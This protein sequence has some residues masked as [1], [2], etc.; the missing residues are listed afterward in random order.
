MRR[1]LAARLAPLRPVILVALS[2]L[3]CESLLGAD[4]DDARARIPAPTEAGHA[5]GA[6]DGEPRSA[7]GHGGRSSEPLGGAS[8]GGRAEPSQAGAGGAGET[9]LGTAGEMP[10]GEGG[11]AGATTG[12]SADEGGAAGVVLG[13][14]GAAGDSGTSDACPSPV[15]PV[16][17]GLATVSPREIPAST[18]ARSVGVVRGGDGAPRCVAALVAASIILT[19]P[20][21]DLRA[22]DPVTFNA[23]R[24]SSGAEA[25]VTE[26]ATSGWQIRDSLFVLAGLAR[27]ANWNEFPQATM[28]ARLPLP[29]EQLRL[30]SHGGDGMSRTHE[31]TVE[32]STFD[33]SRSI[34]MEPLTTVPAFGEDGKLV[35]FCTAD[36]AS[37]ACISMRELLERT[38][39]LAQLEAM[40]GLFWGDST[41]DGREDAVVSNLNGVALR[42]PE[43][44]VLAPMSYWVREGFYGE[45]GN[46]LADIT[47]DGRADLV[48][49]GATV[50][51]REA[52]EFSYGEEVVVAENFFGAASAAAGDV[53]ADGDEDV[54]VLS[55]GVLSIYRSATLGLSLPEVW[56]D[57]LAGGVLALHLVDVTGDGRADAVLVRP[58]RLEVLR[59]S[60]AGFGSPEPFLEGVALGPPGWHF[61]DVTGDGLV[62]AIGIDRARTAIFVSDGARFVPEEQRWS[63]M[64]PIGE[65]G[66][67]VADVTGDGLADVVVHGH[68]SIS[69]YA[70]SGAGTFVPVQIASDAYY[71][72]V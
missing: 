37:A 20:G 36:C 65:R 51:L 28:T 26:L 35:A 23:R 6:G 43:S 30:V 9:A 56:S 32:P 11:A 54:V 38:P 7:G 18:L 47:G 25:T 5:G 2:G 61:G 19:V 41:G 21:C 42:S 27:A 3:A 66:N 17:V 71:G 64:P 60:G 4:F 16:D 14:A 31:I 49:L 59:S 1:G 22:G 50:R 34:G 15:N 48:A 13:A 33:G 57:E 10:G 55:G 62:D 68:A 58:D 53:D 45:R 8:S 24:L 44:G 69:L 46:L 12:V 39:F 70:S 72:G 67:Y 40:G 52:V 29:G 63:P